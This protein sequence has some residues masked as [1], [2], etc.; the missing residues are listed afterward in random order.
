MRRNTK[1]LHPSYWSGEIPAVGEATSF[2][3]D[4]KPPVCVYS[5]WSFFLPSASHQPRQR[6]SF[7]WA[8]GALSPL[9]SLLNDNLHNWDSGEIHCSFLIPDRH[10]A[11]T[12]LQR[13]INSHLHGN[14]RVAFKELTPKDIVQNNGGKGVGNGKN[15]SCW[16]SFS[17]LTGLLSQA[18]QLSSCVSARHCRR[19]ELESVSPPPSSALDLPLE[20][21]LFLSCASFPFLL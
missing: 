1:F 14:W 10:C 3:V 12:F 8:G 4:S 21:L 11:G 15:R 5:N 6:F 18:I 16:S 20:L 7:K 9:L 17:S 13:I 2:T 19:W